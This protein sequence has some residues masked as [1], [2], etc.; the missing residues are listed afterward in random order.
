[1]DVTQFR[2]L[3]ASDQQLLTLSD[4]VI[5]EAL[6]EANLITTVSQFGELKDR[7]AGLYAAHILKVA[8]NR[9][10]GASMHDASSM[11]LGGQSVSFS[12]SSAEMFYNASIYGQRYLALKNSIPTD[13]GNPNLLTGGGP[14]VV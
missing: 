8:A 13:S 11:S 2:Q 7:A 6:D 10:N 9:R 12:R 4:A 3:F 1:M 5:K 14:F